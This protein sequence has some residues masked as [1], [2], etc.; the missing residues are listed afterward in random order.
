LSDGDKGGGMFTEFIEVCGIRGLRRN[1]LNKVP[2][3]IWEEAL[4]LFP[5]LPTGERM[6]WGYRFPPSYTEEEISSVQKRIEEFLKEKMEEEISPP[7]SSP[8]IV[9]ETGDAW[10]LPRKIK[11]YEIIQTHRTGGGGH[12]WY[13]YAQRGLS[14]QEVA[15]GIQQYRKYFPEGEIQV[16]GDTLFIYTSEKGAWIGKEGRWIKALQKVCK[17]KLVSYGEKV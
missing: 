3:D 17:V 1:P 10:T 8:F 12:R 14:P 9:L 11:N 5:D 6:W 4:K 2:A 16:Q 7:S 13:V 15:D